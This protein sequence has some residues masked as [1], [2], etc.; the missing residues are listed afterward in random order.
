MTHF[1][2][3][4]TYKR[5]RRCIGVQTANMCF[6]IN[7]CFLQWDSRRPSGKQRALSYTT[8]PLKVYGSYNCLFVRADEVRKI[9]EQTNLDFGLKQN[10]CRRAALI[11]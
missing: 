4:I 2:L 10:L 11:D 7:W 5:E 1:F 3:N 8:W 9:G 6:R